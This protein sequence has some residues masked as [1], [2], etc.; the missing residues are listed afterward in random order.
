MPQ[1]DDTLFDKLEDYALAIHD[2]HACCG[3][4]GDTPDDLPTLGQEGSDSRDRLRAD[5]GALIQRGL[6]PATAVADCCWLN[7]YK[8]VATDLTFVVTALKKAWPHIQGKCAID[9]AE[10]ERAEQV[11]ARMLRLVG[12]RNLSSAAEADAADRRARVYTLFMKC[13]EVLRRAIGFVRWTEGD[14]DTIMPTLHNNSQ[15]RKSAAQPETKPATQPVPAPVA[16][17]SAT[18]PAPASPVIPGGSP[19]VS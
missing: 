9:E 5:A 13:Y 15:K 19:F 11:A 10:L 7:G 16:P 6:L 14:V 12:A 18:A 17:A 1:F 3:T 2:A 4:A 8:N